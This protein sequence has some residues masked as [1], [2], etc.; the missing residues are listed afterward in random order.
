MRASVETE[1]VGTGSGKSWYSRSGEILE[2]RS[3]GDN[4]PELGAVLE[5]SR[6]LRRRNHNL[7]QVVQK[8]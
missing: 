2:Q 7:L 6:Y 5:Q 8:E 4:D 3:A 1:V